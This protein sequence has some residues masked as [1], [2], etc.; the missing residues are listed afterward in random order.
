M[1]CVP[2]SYINI[3][4][5]A[6]TEFEAFAEEFFLQEMQA[7]PIHFHYS[8]D[9]PSIYNIDE[10]SLTMPIYREGEAAN[11]TYAISMIADKLDKF[12]QMKLSDSNS[13]LC[14]LMRSYIDTVSRTASYP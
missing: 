14:G 13:Y 8:V 1:I 9:D 10:S 5:H 6:D 2:Y 12:D 11:D 7:N 3:N 4:R